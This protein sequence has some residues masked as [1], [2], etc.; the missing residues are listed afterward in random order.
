MVPG[1]VRIAILSLV[2]T[3]CSDEAP[4]STSDKVKP[5]STDTILHQQKLRLSLPFD[6]ERDFEEQQRGFIAAPTYRQIVEPA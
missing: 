5:P 3:A 1:F 4:P 2:V 6:D